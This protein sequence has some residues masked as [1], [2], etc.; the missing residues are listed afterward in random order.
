MSEDEWRPRRPVWV[1][2]LVAL[3]LVPIVV[4]AVL[5][6]LRPMGRAYFP[7]MGYYPFFFFPFGWVFAFLILFFLLRMIFWPW[8]WGSRR[9]YRGYPYEYHILRVRYARGEITKEQF[10]QMT[11]DLQESNQK[12]QKPT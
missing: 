3:I 11:H 6:V 9:R 2:L 5:Y 10:D 7:F 1:G 12:T 8:G 4:S